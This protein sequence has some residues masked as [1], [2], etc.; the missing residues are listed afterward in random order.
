MSSQTTTTTASDSPD[1]EGGEK[2][3]YDQTPVST[4]AKD[5]RTL[6]HFLSGRTAER[7]WVRG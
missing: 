7:K 2:R 1:F 3:L 4:Q 5:K 6:P